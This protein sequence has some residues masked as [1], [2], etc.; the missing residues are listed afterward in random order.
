MPKR[1]TPQQTADRESF[2]LEKVRA[3][4]SRTQIQALICAEFGVTERNAGRIYNMAIDGIVQRDPGEQRRNRAMML[5]MLYFQAS[6][7]QA[8]I[9]A[10]QALITTARLQPEVKP[11]AIAQMIGEKSRVRAQ[12]IKTLSDIS[13]IYGLYTDMPLLQAI[14]VLANSEMLP[15]ELAGRML[16]A[17]EDISSSIE[18][19]LH[20]PSQPEQTTD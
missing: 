6:S 1:L 2:V 10:L 17:I 13:R 16:V 8:D 18:K 14:S 5:E 15:P 9:A 4:L 19:S 3:N 7:S 12:L 11:N 20:Q